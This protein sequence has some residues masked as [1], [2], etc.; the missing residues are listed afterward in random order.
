[1]WC[2]FDDILTFKKKNLCVCTYNTFKHTTIKKTTKDKKNNPHV[3]Q[4]CKIQHKMHLNTP[5]DVI[6]PQAFLQVDIIKAPTKLSVDPGWICTFSRVTKIS[7][8]LCSSKIP[9]RKLFHR[10][11]PSS[12]DISEGGS[13]Q[14]K[15]D[16]TCQRCHTE[17]ITTK[18]MKTV[19]WLTFLTSSVL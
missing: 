17:E 13:G 5:T 3:Y 1:M 16:G 9:A 14:R 4:M 6:W 19:R 11:S 15:L 10:F 18:I 8:P 12:L 7:S 2:F